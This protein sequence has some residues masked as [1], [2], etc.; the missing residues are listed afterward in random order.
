M[1]DLAVRCDSCGATI[2]TDATSNTY[3]CDF[4]N[5][6]Y[7]RTVQTSMLSPNTTPPTETSLLYML[8]L[9]SYVNKEKT[10]KTYMELV[11]CNFHD[12]HSSLQNLPL[13][14][15]SGISKTQ[16]MNLA[17]KFYNAGCIFDIVVDTSANSP[18]DSNIKPYLDEINK[19]LKSTFLQYKTI[20]VHNTRAGINLERSDD[21]FYPKAVER[22]QIPLEERIYYIKDATILGFLKKGFAIGSTGIYYRTYDN[23]VGFLSWND[24]TTVD[25]TLKDTQLF[26]GNLLFFIGE[27]NEVFD[28]IKF[29]QTAIGDIIKN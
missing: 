23:L 10:V 4:C 19:F 17:G 7:S 24:F 18:S 5:T 9:N 29:L 28:L 27:P 14:I 12:A 2:L 22:F 16:A 11:N 20:A 13:T 21:K 8:I 25:I 26:I 1:A 3:K 6:Y 15:A